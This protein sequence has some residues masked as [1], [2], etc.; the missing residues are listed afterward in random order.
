M[1]S[2]PL[3]DPRLLA[4]ERELEAGSLDE[5]QRLLGDLGDAPALR[6]GTTYLAT[7]LLFLRGRLD[8]QGVAERLTDLL[9]TVQ[10]FPQ[11]EALLA[12]AE[13]HLSTSA[14]GARAGHTPIVE[15]TGGAT[16]SDLA[17]NASPRAPRVTPMSIPRA[18]GLPYF[19]APADSTP[20]YA[21]EQRKPSEP[22][23]RSG[24]P[25]PPVLGALPSLFELAGMLD[26]HE[27]RQVINAI[28]TAGGVPSPDYA[29]MRARALTGEKQTADAL[30]ML[31]PLCA[32]P[33]LD[34]ELRAGCAKLL[35]ELGH[36]RPALAQAEKAYAD[37]PEP[38]AVALTLA[39]ALVRVARRESDRRQALLERADQILGAFSAHNLPRAALFTAL[40]ASVQAEIGD[41]ERAVALAGRALGMDHMSPDALAAL[42]VGSARLDRAHDAQQ[43]WL[44]LLDSSYAEADALSEQLEGLGVSLAKLNP[45]DRPGTHSAHPPPPVWDS[46]E[47]AVLE[48]RR[49]DAAVAFEAL[50]RDRLTQLAEHAR[51]RDLPVV[52]T[53]GANFLTTSPVSRNFAPFD[54]SLWSIARLEAVLDVLYGSEPRPKLDSDDY[55][56]V[57]LLGAYLGETLRGAHAARWRGSLS[58]IDSACVETAGGA[59]K[60][61]ELVRARIRSGGRLALDTRLGALAH[62]GSKPWAHRIPNPVAPPCPWDGA[63]WPDVDRAR[64]LGQALSSS[65]FGEYCEQALGTPLDRSLASIA[66]LDGYLALIAPDEAPAEVH[67]PWAPRIALLAGAYLAE[68]LRESLG[69]E[70][71]TAPDGVL[72]PAS[73]RVRVGAHEV[74]PVEEV[75][76]RIER[77]VSTPLSDL[78]VDLG[79]G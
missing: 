47:C 3:D 60:P 50:G 62:P 27:F 69:G 43:A 31:K 52:A 67:P 57:V 2:G 18:P 8:A 16:L 65:I 40:R 58:E 13:Q 24:T 29:L 56:I 61:F 54:L 42:A 10:G 6:A 63:G 71:L 23:I 30:A 44:R 33:L 9:Q 77:R 7:R 74:R 73:Y 17:S 49:S 37:D 12:A 21:P 46:V 64:E 79:H 55:P 70:W 66:A 48:E 75:L 34:P 4:I 53:V 59:W 5:A 39:W 68:T 41:A 14:R 20:S 35:L 76:A 25:P 1:T 45:A 11:A 72:G 15:V 36:A 22:R 26:Q 32:A 78:T 28:D 19:S 51:A 38:P